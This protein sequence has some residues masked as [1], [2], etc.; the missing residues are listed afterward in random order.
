MLRLRHYFWYVFLPLLVVAIWY[1]WQRDTNEFPETIEVGEVTRSTVSEVLTE[2]GVVKSLQAVD[3]AFERGGRVAKVYQQ[4]G[5]VVVLGTPLMELDTT[6]LEAQV[7]VAEARV[8]GEE[9]RLSELLRGADAVG[10]AVTDATVQ[11]AVVA[12]ENAERAKKE[13]AAQQDLLVANA[14]QALLSTGLVAYLQTPE[15]GSGSYESPVI[16]GTYND[17]EEGVYR[18][19]LYNSSAVSGASYRVSGLETGGGEVSTVTPTPLGSRGLYIQF[20]DNFAARTVWEIPVPN[21]RANSYLNLLSAYNT[22]LDTSRV[23][24]SAAENVQRTA[25]ANLAH[26]ESQKNQAVSAARSERVLAQQALLE[27]MRAALTQAEAALSYS[28]LRAPFTGVVTQTAA[29]AGEIVSPGQPVV[30]FRSTDGFELEVA[31]SEIDIAEVTVG[32]TA[33]VAFDAYEDLLLDATVTKIAPAV[34]VENGLHTFMVTLALPKQDERLRDGLT[35]EIELTTALRSEVVAV[36]T[37]AIYED[38]SG[39]F[40]RVVGAGDTVTRAPVT[41]GLRGTDGMTEILT[42]LS[43]GER[44]IMFASEE[45]LKLISS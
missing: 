15:R 21:T 10:L 19:E 7:R 14:R 3:L 35:A 27:Q 11:A 25:E 13:T 32:D 29:E 39:K 4:I 31:I 26:V 24:R 16:S 22:A 6:E 41:T 45:D 18:V 8:L 37:R 44:I 9:A 43:G 5:D 20:P 36:P 17:D 23:A 30:S 2:T 38:E 28:S 1:L 33:T 34:T 42:G 12:V 40:V